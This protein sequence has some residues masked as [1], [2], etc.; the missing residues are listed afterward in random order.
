MS[1]SEIINATYL[2]ETRSH[3]SVEHIPPPYELLDID[4]ESGSPKR[5]R[6]KLVA[7]LIALYLSL[8]IAAMDQVCVATIIPTIASSL[9]SSSGFSWIGG[10]Y[11]LAAA[12]AAPVWAKLSDIWGRKPILLVVVLWFGLASIIC[13][14]AQNMPALITGRSLQGVAGGGLIQLVTITLSDIFSMR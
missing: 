14:T 6:A 4:A 13:A 11:L 7:V 3:G 10:S 5:S 1:S 9:K 8:F 12:G 2:A